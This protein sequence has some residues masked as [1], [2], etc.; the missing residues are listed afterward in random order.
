MQDLF[1]LARHY[2]FGQIHFKRCTKTGMHSIIAI[3]STKLGPALG[4]C[5]F[6]EYRDSDLATIDSLRLA[7]GMSYKAAMANLPLGGGKSVIIRPHEKFSREDYMHSF[8][9]FVHSLGGNYITAL[10]SG[11]E[12]SDMDIIA[13]ETPYVA[14]HSKK[15]GDPSP[16]TVDGVIA[17][18]KASVQFKLKKESL[19]GLHMAIQGLGHVGHG[20]AQKLHEEGVDLTI[21]DINTSL[22]DQISKELNAN[23]VASN[24]IHKTPCDVFIP[25]AL[26]G[27]LNTTTISELNCKIIAGA[28]NNQLIDSEAG[29][30]LHLEGIL[31][32]PDY[33]INAGGLIFACGKYFNT[34]IEKINAQIQHIHPRMLDI[35][36]QSE[37]E[38]IPTNVLVDKIARAKIS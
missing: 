23:V 22:A 6:I 12:L 26:G 16:C 30:A 13:Q 25:C 27:I 9:K 36:Q 19:K 35:Y 32:A 14:S 21:T 7:Q 2:D 15:H 5:R 33:V 11:T 8:G 37:A 3:H 10:D 1:N 20:V 38:N 31:Y 28:A 29:L 34:P 18:I 4:G 24:N 17:G